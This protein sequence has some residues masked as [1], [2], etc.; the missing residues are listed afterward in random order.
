MPK[1]VAKYSM[2]LLSSLS[3][4]ACQ[5][6]RVPSS[7]THPSKG[8]GQV[9][10]KFL[11]LKA[12]GYTGNCL[13]D[14]AKVDIYLLGSGGNF[15]VSQQALDVSVSGGSASFTV[16]VGTNYA[17]KAVGKTSAGALMEWRRFRGL[18]ATA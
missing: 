16:P 7:F 1:S 13:P 3:L 5:A 14:L 8:V 15:G 18:A 10:L 17:I 11:G 12:L 9:Q 4:L 2:L 6:T